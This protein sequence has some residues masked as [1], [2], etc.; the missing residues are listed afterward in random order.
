M[1]LIKCS[2]CEKSKNILEFHI[3]TSNKTGYQS[4]CKLCNK[5]IQ[6]LYYINNRTSALERKLK[7]RSTKEYKLKSRLYELNVYS[8]V[9]IINGKTFNVKFGGVLRDMVRRCL[10]HKG[11]KKTTPTFEIL[12]YDTYKLKQRLECQLK[13]GMSWDNYGE[14]HIDHKKPICK[15]DKGSKI[16]TINSLSNLQPLWASENLSKGCKFF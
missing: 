1:N 12:G 13:E 16:S 10:N 15:F 8:K 11:C 6:R 5:E 9:R 3:N 7:Y 14:W 4:Y 2:R